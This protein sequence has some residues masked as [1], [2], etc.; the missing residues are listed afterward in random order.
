[1]ITLTTAYDGSAIEGEGHR[2]LRLAHHTCSRQNSTC[3]DAA[4]SALSDHQAHQIK[5]MDRHIYQQR[6]PDATGDNADKT[7]GGTTIASKSMLMLPRCPWLAAQ[8][9]AQPLVLP[10]R[11][12]Q[13]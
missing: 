2:T 7:T 4:V 13:F 12:R 5:V 1:M 11:N 6:L 3:T 9:D 10:D 8:S